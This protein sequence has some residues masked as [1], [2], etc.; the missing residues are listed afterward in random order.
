[1]RFLAIL[2][3]VIAP[4]GDLNDIAKANKLKKEAKEAF[5]N[6][7]YE[8]AIRH[9]RY[10]LD[11]MQLDDDNIRLNLANA[12][13]QLQ[14]TTSALNGY[15]SLASSSEKSVKSVAHQQLG[16]M[17]NR[18]KKFDEA[19]NHFKQ[20][21]RSDP[22]NEDARYNYEL[23]KKMLKEQ[24]QQQQNQDQQN[25]DQQNQ[26]QQ[27][28]QDQQQKDQQQEKQ[29]QKDQQQE[30]D[31]QG[32]NSEQQDQQG[33]QDQEK[34]DQQEQENEQKQEQEGKEK[35][36]EQSQESEQQQQ[37]EQNEQDQKVPPSTL[38]KLKEMNISE[39]KAR[40]IL[41]A[42]KNQEIQYLQQMKRKPKKSRDTGKP[43]W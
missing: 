22:A 24:E 13:Y 37:E 25:Q 29:E 7:D 16:I 35:E 28:Q 36:E 15:Q 2:F 43:D 14:D 23:L 17:A 11:S 41:E 33:E 26:D 20:A 39:E 9:Y 30:Q 10:L 27:Q 4:F 8:K 3:L 21:L 38:D 1:M 6:G 12:Y 32:E 31:Q 18:E 19:L 34:K 5:H 42:M 40:M